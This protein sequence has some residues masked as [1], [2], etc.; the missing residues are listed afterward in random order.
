MSLPAEL[1]VGPSWS[2]IHFA[3]S[4]PDVSALGDLELAVGEF[5]AADVVD[6]PTLFGALSA[7]FN[8]PEYFGANWDAADELLRDMGWLPAAGYTL[9]VRGSDSLWR[10]DPELAARLVR[11]WLYCAEHWAERGVAFHLVFE[12]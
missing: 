7:A 1:L 8:F 11:A 2:C 3:Q 5:D 9:I 6:E 12:W 4:G 10:S